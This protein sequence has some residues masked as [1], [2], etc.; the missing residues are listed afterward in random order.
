M[1]ISW[2]TSGWSSKSNLYSPSFFRVPSGNLIIPFSIS[3]PCSLRASEISLVPIE[4]YKVPSSE[5]GTVIEISKDSNLLTKSNANDFLSNS[6]FS[7]DDF[8]CS[9]SA[10]FSSFALIALLKGIRKFLA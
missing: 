1:E 10:L 3:I 4:P 5:T 9:Y 6:A 2:I 7:K 8:L